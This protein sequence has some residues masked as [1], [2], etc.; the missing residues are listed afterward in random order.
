MYNRIKNRFVLSKKTS[1]FH[2]SD[3]PDPQ[4]CQ[5]SAEMQYF[6]LLIFRHVVR[7][8]NSNQAQVLDWETTAKST[9]ENKSG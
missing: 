9:S 6:S 7:I 5:C 2:S 4:F 3:D 8:E 1:F